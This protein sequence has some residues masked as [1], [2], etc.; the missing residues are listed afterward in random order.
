MEPLSRLPHLSL[1]QVGSY[2]FSAPTQ[3]VIAFRLASLIPSLHTIGLL[4]EKGD[5]NWWGLWRRVKQRTA[6]PIGEYHERLDVK[7]VP[8]GDGHLKELEKES[9]RQRK[10]SLPTPSELQAMITPPDS[11]DQIMEDESIVEG[12]AKVGVDQRGDDPGS[13]LGRS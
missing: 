9:E 8:L 1:L 10:A 5:T 6:V 4:G 7:L 12:D 11:Q 2:T 3:T 13:R